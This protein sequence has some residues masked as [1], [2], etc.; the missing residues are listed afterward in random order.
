LLLL[1]LAV[2]C[3]ALSPTGDWNAA[4]AAFLSIGMTVR[5]ASP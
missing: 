5:S 2:A 3:A 4:L 1:P